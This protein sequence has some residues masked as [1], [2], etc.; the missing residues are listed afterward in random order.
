MRFVI[1][2]L[3]LAALGCGLIY[4]HQQ[5]QDNLISD[6]QGYVEA[7]EALHS[8]VEPYKSCIE[9]MLTRRRMTV[10]IFTFR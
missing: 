2:T 3:L 7:C 10:E 1:F 8:S 4:S 9:E 6:M 5:S